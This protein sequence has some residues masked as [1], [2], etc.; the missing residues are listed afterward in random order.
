MRLAALLLLIAIHAVAQATPPQK[1]DP[2]KEAIVVEHYVSHN[3]F[4]DDGNAIREVSA[5]VHVQAEAGV[6]ALAVLRFQYSTE[7]EA[8]DIEYV[9]VRKPDGSLV[10]TPAYNIQDMPGEVTR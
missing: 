9:R 8:V 10:L 5:V 4:Q 6:Q 1:S 3:T 2:S 7:T